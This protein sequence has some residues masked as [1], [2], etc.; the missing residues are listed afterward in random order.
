MGTSKHMQTNQSVCENF[1]HISH[2]DERGVVMRMR[3]C[4]YEDER[5]WFCMSF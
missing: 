3:G 4:G 2:E 5:V 1:D